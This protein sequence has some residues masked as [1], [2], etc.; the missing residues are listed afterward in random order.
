MIFGM[1]AS[2]IATLL[3]AVATPMGLIGVGL[4]TLISRADARAKAR[5]DG[6][7]KR[8]ADLEAK[9]DRMAQREIVLFRRVF[10]LEGIMRARGIDLPASVGW[11]L[12]EDR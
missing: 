2:E 4:K 7:E 12:P 1:Q 3:G 6:F 5:E 9:I 8:I 11:P 10:E